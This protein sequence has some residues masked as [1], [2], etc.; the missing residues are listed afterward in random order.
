MLKFSRFAGLTSCLGEVATTSTLHTLNQQSPT[1]KLIPFR[2]WQHLGKSLCSEYIKNKWMTTQ[3][4]LD[5]QT[6]SE[7]KLGKQLQKPL[8]QNCLDTEADL[9]SGISRKRS[10][11]SSSCWFTE[12]CNSQCLSH[13]AAP[14]IGVRAETSIAEGCSLQRYETMTAHVSLKSNSVYQIGDNVVTRTDQVLAPSTRQPPP[15]FSLEDHDASRC[16]TST[17]PREPHAVV[18]SSEF[19]GIITC[20]WSFRRFTYGNLVTTSPSSK[21]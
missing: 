1:I 19:Q 13:F 20:E 18:R 6:R 5:A 16:D 3:A 15:S 4:T 9:L 14:F 8:S 10:V 17:A 21:Q 12:C 2:C 7:N 11:R